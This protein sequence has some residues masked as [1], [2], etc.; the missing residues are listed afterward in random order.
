MTTSENAVPSYN[1][2]DSIKFLSTYSAVD[3]LPGCAGM[4]SEQKQ[5]K[6]CCYKLKTKIL[7]KIERRGTLYL[8]F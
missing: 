3:N 1:F 5:Q 7:L 6:H 2:P 8:Y 4:F